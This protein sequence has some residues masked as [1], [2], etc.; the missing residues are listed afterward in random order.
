MVDEKK[1]HLGR[2]AKFYFAEKLT[3]AGFVSYNQEFLSWYKVVNQEVLLT[4]YLY[5]SVSGLP[6]IP[7]LGYGYHPL[8]ITAPV[9]QSFSVR[10]Y[11][12][13]DVLMNI[14][15]FDRP[16][17]KLFDAHTLVD[18]PATP[19]GG[20]EK[21]NEIV[22]PVFDQIH[23]A[24]DAYRLHTELFLNRLKE[25]QCKFPGQEYNGRISCLD[26]I[27]E[28]IY[29]GDPEMLQIFARDTTVRGGLFGKNLHRVHAQYS[30]IF[31]GK[32]EEYL[33]ILEK[34]RQ[35]NIKNLRKKLN[36]TIA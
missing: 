5:N 13:D 35:K 8:Y 20:A 21:L 25:Y 28:L 23:C 36:L 26:Y 15:S 18:H 30:A 31:E 32:R 12:W 27:D 29:Y 9:P 10:G 24:E 7:E 4:V 2:W 14:V 3:A 6:A 16:A 19:E 17:G 1:E 11:G 33:E 34:R 22:F